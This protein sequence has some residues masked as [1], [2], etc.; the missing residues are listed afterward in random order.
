MRKYLFASI[1]LLAFASPALAYESAEVSCGVCLKKFSTVVGATAGVG[2]VVGAAALI[3]AHRNYT[4]GELR[5]EADPAH[6]SF[7]ANAKQFQ[8]TPA[9]A[10]VN[11]PSQPTFAQGTY[12]W[13]WAN[14]QR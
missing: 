9:M 11:Q 13:G 10:L 5:A 12:R 3:Y 14:E 1:A 2:V 7:L 6:E 4:K 8:G